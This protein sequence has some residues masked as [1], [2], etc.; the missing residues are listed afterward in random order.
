M[1]RCLRGGGGRRRE[2]FCQPKWQTAT[3]W[4][5]AKERCIS[6]LLLLKSVFKMRSLGRRSC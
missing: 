5:L 6:C 1:V 4:I 3:R 2:N